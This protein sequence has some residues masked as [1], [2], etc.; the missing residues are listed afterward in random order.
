MRV[1]RNGRRDR[2]KICFCKECRF[3]SD[4]PYQIVLKRS[5]AQDPVDPLNG[6]QEVDGSI[7]SGS[8]NLLND[9]NELSAFGR[10]F[11]V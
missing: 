9:Y 2:L 8:T 5:C 1:W 3:E 11:F 10:F 6:I 7:P 4:H